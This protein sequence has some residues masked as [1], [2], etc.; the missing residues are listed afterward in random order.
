MRSFEVSLEL[1]NVSKRSTLKKIKSIVIRPIFIGTII[2][3]ILFTIVMLTKLVTFLF[4]SNALFNLN[5]YDIT[6]AMIG[7]CIGFSI[8]LLLKLRNILK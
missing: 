8:D 7:F 2:F 1:E 6:F 4:S 3:A 5:L